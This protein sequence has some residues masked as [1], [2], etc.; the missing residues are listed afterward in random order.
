VEWS[1]TNGP[2]IEARGVD[3]AFPG[4]QALSGVDLTVHRGEIV[5]LVGENGAGKSTLLSVLSGTVRPDAGAVHVRGREVQFGNYREATL[6]GVFRI[7]QEL[8]LV[9]NL[10]VYENLF[11]SHEGRFRRLGVLRRGAMLR[12]ARELLARFGHDWIDPARPTAAYDF[13]TRQV[14][15][16]I[17]AF[18]L[19]EL[20]DVEAPVILLD[21]PTTALTRDEADFLGEL[22]GRVRS[23]AALVFVSHR[24]SEVLELSDRVY[25]LKDG[26]VVEE[27]EPER[28]TDA[29]VHYVMVGRERDELF[30]HESRQ[31]QPDADA[32]L[33]VKGFAQ[34]PEFRD[35]SFVVRKGEIVG[36][37]GVLGSGKSALARAIFGAGVSRAE[38]T[39]RV[40]GHA[41]EPLITR[42]MVR[43]GV[44]YVPPERHED[45][46]ILGFPVAWNISLAR[47]AAG[48]GPASLLNADRERNEARGFVDSMRIKTPDVRTQAGSLS[49][50]NQQKVV[51]ARWLACDARMLILDN[52][53]RGIDAGAKEE[54]YALI[55]DLADRGVGI[56]VVSDDLLELIGLSN[57]ILIMKDGAI[58][59]ELDSPPAQKPQEST[60]VASMV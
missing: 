9:P 34:P 26:R 37:G 11:L 17:K 32:V 59:A 18:A 31:R 16:I 29:Q 38:G 40:D 49:G 22:L 2:L 6:E 43:A 48:N 13:S 46:I 1:S 58:T 53:T 60:L 24:L 5:G 57:R 14:L 19:G 36:I 20:L 12:R 21:E 45:G 55:R 54:I 8:A 30:Y 28:T 50:G 56:L 33:E 51:L 23:E 41:M 10:T 52:P 27:T 42:R 39:V 47:L 35:V 44:G 7:Y 3:K 25:I 15:E 4:V